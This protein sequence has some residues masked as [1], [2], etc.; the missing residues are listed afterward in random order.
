[1][2]LV[3]GVWPSTEVAN[4]GTASASGQN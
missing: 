2:F 4:T 1:M 3:G